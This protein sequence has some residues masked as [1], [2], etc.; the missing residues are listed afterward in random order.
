MTL[1]D[2]L[3][4]G[5]SGATANH[6]LVV[7][8]SARALFDLEASHALF[9]RDGVAAYAEL[10]AAARG[11]NAGTGHRVPAGAQA[12]RAQSHRAAG[13][14]E[15]RSHPAV[16]QFLRYRAAHLQRDRAPRPRYRPRGVHQRRTDLALHQTVRRAPVP[17]GQSRNRCDARWNTAW[18]RPRSCRRAHPDNDTGRAAHRLRRR[19][20]DLRRRVRAHLARAGVEAFA[21][22]E[23]ELAEQPLSGGPF[24]G[25][26]GALHDIQGAF[27]PD[28]SRRSAPRSSPRVRPRRTSA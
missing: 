6:K 18:L 28:E 13:S 3:P 21:R 5:E 9:E 19:R 20:G 14:A 1:A 16:A 23:I 27:G 7:A 2:R 12:A 15:G 26:L 22:N 11:R 8:L 10:P 4:L 17:V 24:R 25:F